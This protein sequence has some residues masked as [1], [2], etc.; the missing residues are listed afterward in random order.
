M[1]VEAVE[2]DGCRGRG[3]QRVYE[4]ECAGGARNVAR[5]VAP[6]GIVVI[7]IGAII[8]AVDAIGAIGREADKR[9]EGRGHGGGGLGWPPG[10]S[11]LGAGRC[12]GEGADGA[13]HGLDEER[14]VRGRDWDCGQRTGRGARGARGTRGTRGSYDAF[15]SGRSCFVR[16]VRFVRIAS[17]VFHF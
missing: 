17:G 8:D 9:V 15:R 10:R 4:V 14:Q 5:D 3:E 11:R 6:T 13:Q 7:I 16:F 2:R 1:A 12:E